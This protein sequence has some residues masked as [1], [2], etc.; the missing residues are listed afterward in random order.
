MRPALRRAHRERPPTPTCVIEITQRRRGY[1]DPDEQKQMDRAAH[2]PSRRSRDFRYRAGCT[3]ADRPG[4]RE[5]RRVIRT[6]GTDRRQRELEPVAAICTASGLVGNASMAGWRQPAATANSGDRVE[7][8]A[9]LHRSGGAELMAQAQRSPP[10]RRHRAH[11]PPG[12]WRLLP[13]RLRRATAAA[14]RVYVLIDCGYKPGSPEFI[15]HNKP[16]GDIVEPTSS[17]PR[18][19][20]I[21]LAILTHEHQDHLNGI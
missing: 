7:P 2:A 8:F 15:K 16:I 19:G 12:A 6:P 4:D 18:G 14:T 1:F 21:D 20:H 10:E 3:V 5:I 9:L 17:R 13:A 11:V